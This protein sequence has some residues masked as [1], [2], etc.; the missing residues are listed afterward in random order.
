MRVT[1]LE[2]A[3]KNEGI[4]GP[5]VDIPFEMIYIIFGFLPLADIMN[6]ERYPRVS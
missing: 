3:R 5:I 6:C 1:M 4:M 2:E